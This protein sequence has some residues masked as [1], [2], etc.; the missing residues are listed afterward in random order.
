MD[1]MGK[2]IATKDFQQQTTIDLSAIAKGIYLVQLTNSKGE[3]G[4]Y[5]LVKE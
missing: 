1:M 5:K 2:T 4:V 3:K